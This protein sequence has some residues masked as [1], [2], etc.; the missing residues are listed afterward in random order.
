MQNVI[1]NCHTK[2]FNH[3]YTSPGLPHRGNVHNQPYFLNTMMWSVK[4]KIKSRRILC[5]LTSQHYKN[6]Q[7][8]MKL[9]LQ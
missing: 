2:E 5:K 7:A 9:T 4:G 6:F 8:E 1:F 3:I